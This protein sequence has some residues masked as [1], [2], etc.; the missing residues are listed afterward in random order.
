V[1]FHVGIG[2]ILPIGFAGIAGSDVPPI[3]NDL[4]GFSG[5][6]GN[7]GGRGGSHKQDSNHD[8]AKDFYDFV[9]HYILLL[10]DF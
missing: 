9:A 8:E 6:G 5:G 2:H 3:D 7:G 4:I 10:F 1:S